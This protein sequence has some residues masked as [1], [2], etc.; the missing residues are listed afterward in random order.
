MVEGATGVGDAQPLVPTAPD[1]REP[2]N[3]PV[4]IIIR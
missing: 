2:Q 4:E 1:V 3:R